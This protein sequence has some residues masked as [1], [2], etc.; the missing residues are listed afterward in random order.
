MYVYNPPA[1]IGLPAVALGLLRRVPFVFDICDL[2]PDTVAAS[3]MLSNPAAL[4]LLG[5]DHLDADAAGMTL[6]SVLKY[7]EDLDL[8]RSRGLDWVAAG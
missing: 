4:T 2:W 8:V 5:I 3:G 1:T 6:G 7:T